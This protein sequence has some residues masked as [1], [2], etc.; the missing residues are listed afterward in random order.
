MTVHDRT[1]LIGQLQLIQK[2][3]YSAICMGVLRYAAEAA[4]DDE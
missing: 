3:P 1:R 4:E 2:R